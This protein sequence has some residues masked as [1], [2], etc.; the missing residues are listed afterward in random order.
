MVSEI[1]IFIDTSGFKAL[2]DK[3]DAFFTQVWALWPKLQNS[4][5]ARLV[6]SNYILDESFTLIRLRCGLQV[7][8]DLQ[9]MISKSSMSISIER[10]TT[11]DEKDAWE[12]FQNDWSKLSFTDCTSFAL[13]KRLEITRVVTFDEHFKRA[14]FVPEH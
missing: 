8:M 6:T 4:P 14:G 10:V 2:L 11:E 13:M 9:D 12:W 3:N 7:A 5:S 1:E